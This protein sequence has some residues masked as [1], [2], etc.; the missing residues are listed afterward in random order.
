[1]GLILFAIF[2]LI[3]GF[4]ARAVMPGT[5]KMG[6]VATT[7]LG[8][9]GSFLGGFLA[10]LVTSRAVTDLSTAGFFGSVIGALL[11][12]FIAGKFFGHRSLV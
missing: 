7:A 6:L 3:V 12:L 1:M 5:Q 2:G 4:I 9:G 11:L 8:I 10:S